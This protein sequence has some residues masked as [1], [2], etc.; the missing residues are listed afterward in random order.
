VIATHSPQVAARCERIAEMVDGRILR[1][2][3]G[4]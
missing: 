3:D 1:Q 2:A 4:G